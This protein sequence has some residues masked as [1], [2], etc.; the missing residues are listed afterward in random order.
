MRNFILY[1]SGEHWQGQNCSN[2]NCGC[3]GRFNYVVEIFL[4]SN[5]N[6]LF[7]GLSFIIVVVNRIFRLWNSCG[8]EGNLRRANTEP[9]M[10]FRR[11]DTELSMEFRKANTELST[12]FRRANME[13]YYK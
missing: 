13:T 12:Y 5:L 7:C 3:D 8:I 4:Y 2:N 1:K 11:A 9:S 6:R 10:H